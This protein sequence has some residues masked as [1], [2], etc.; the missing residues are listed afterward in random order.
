L[1]SSARSALEG[2]SIAVMLTCVSACA[3]ALF[4][5]PTGPGAPAPEAA[6]A[7]DDATQ[8]C[9]GVTS[10]TGSLRVSGHVGGDRLPATIDVLTGATPAAFRL[11]GQA[12]GREIFRL[13]GTA[14]R[15]TL[16]LDDGHRFAT[17]QSEALTD[18]LIGVK[19]GPERWLALLTGC[20]AAPP[21]FISGGRYG[22]EIAVTTPGGRVFLVIANGTWQ[23]M[24]G[25]FDGLVLT[26]RPFTS[27]LPEAWRLRSEAGRDPSVDLTVEVDHATAGRP[28]PS[29]AFA[30]TLPD[31]ARSMSLDELRQNGPLRKKGT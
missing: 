17:G 23:A 15:A 29:S 14:D 11:E 8:A 2:A 12:S 27:T 13:A 30:V 24:D 9:R 16:Y 10:Y 31:D 5:P 20:V 25:L 7:W 22:A 28:I 1:R 4:V 3:P 19:L 21:D 18:A 6:A 26:Y